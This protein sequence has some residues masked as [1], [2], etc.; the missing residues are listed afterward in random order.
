[1]RGRDKIN[2]I[3]PDELILEI[4]KHLTSK[5]NRDA[6]SLVCKR[7]R[8]LERLSRETVRIAASGSPDAL[9][10]L[11]ASR[12]VNVRNLYIDERLTISL[13]VEFV[14]YDLCFIFV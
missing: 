14:S 2:P 7:W 6:C 13:P 9:V 4:F 11:L 1:M 12:F 10:E 8:R 3:L 5:S